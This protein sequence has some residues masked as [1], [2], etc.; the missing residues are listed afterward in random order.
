MQGIVANFV[1]ARSFTNSDFFEDVR[2]H[3]QIYI[4]DVDEGWLEVY[5]PRPEW[6][7]LLQARWPQAKFVD[8]LKWRST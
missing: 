3:A 8:S 6:L 4:L 5:S 2:Y 1:A 7:E